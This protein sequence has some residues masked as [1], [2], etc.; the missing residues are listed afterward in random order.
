M[1]AFSMES[2]I[3]IPC[4]PGDGEAELRLRPAVRRRARPDFNLGPGP[5]SFFHPSHEAAD[6]DVGVR[7]RRNRP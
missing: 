5:S 6:Q 4:S 2:K 7:A 3:G 1:I